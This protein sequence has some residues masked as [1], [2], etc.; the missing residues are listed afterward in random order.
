M[1]RWMKNKQEKFWLNRVYGKIVD[2]MAGE[3]QRRSPEQHT[4]YPHPTE[5][6]PYK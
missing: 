3:P 2:W 5:V 1:D 4:I 6:P